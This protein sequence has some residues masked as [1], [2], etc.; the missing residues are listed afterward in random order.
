MDI[1][2]KQ[3]ISGPGFDYKCFKLKI[4]DSPCFFKRLMAFSTSP[5][6]NQISY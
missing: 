5:I 3:Q 2:F 4:T 1:F 6:T